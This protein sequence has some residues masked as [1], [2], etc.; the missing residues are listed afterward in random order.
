MTKSIALRIV[1]E[2]AGEYRYVCETSDIRDSERN[3]S[4]TQ[5]ELN[6]AL[7][8]VESRIVVLRAISDE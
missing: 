3:R 5:D 8:I 4:F 1:L 7:E 2:A 6:E